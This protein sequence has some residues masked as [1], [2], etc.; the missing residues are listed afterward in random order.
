MRITLVTETYY[1]QVNGV[2]RTLGQLVRVLE[3]A[4]DAVQLIQ[5]DYGDPPVHE[6][7]CLLRAVNPPFYRELFVPLPPFRKSFDAIDTFGPDLVHIATEGGLG[8]SVLRHAQTRFPCRFELPY[9]L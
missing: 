1:P 8:L 6:H 7:D 4:G 5:P 3:E 9:E 2:S